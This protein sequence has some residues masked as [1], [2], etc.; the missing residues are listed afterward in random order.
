MSIMIKLNTKNIIRQAGIR[1]FETLSNDSH[2][3]D[4]VTIGVDYLYRRTLMFDN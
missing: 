4:R 2:D 3:S 1:R